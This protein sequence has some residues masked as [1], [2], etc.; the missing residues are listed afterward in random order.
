MQNK[1]KQNESFSDVDRSVQ[2][3]QKAFYSASI[4]STLLRSAAAKS[5][6]LH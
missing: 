2:F 1:K 6:L 5:A 4:P 3:D